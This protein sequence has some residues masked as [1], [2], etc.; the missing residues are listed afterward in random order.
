M[1]PACATWITT[2]AASFDEPGHTSGFEDEV[3]VI[4]TASHG[5]TLAS[6]GIYCDHQTADHHVGAGT[7]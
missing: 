4:I 2:W 3:G 6:F 5:E 1:T 7:P